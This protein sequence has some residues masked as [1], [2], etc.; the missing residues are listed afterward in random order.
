MHCKWIQFIYLYDHSGGNT[1]KILARNHQYLGVNEAIKAYEARKLNDGKL[2]VFWHTQGSGK[3]YSMV[4]LAQKI[5][6]KFAGS[7]TIVVLT[8]R[9]ELNKQISDTFEN[10]G[11]LGKTNVWYSLKSKDKLGKLSQNVS[12]TMIDENRI[13]EAVDCYNMGKDVRLYRQDKL[14]MK[15]KNY[16]FDLYKTAFRTMWSKRFVI[17]IP[18][19]ITE[20]LVK[21]VMYVFVCAYSIAGVFGVGSIIK[22]V[23]FIKALIDCIT[24]G[25]SVFGDIKYNTPFVR[26]YLTYFD[27]PKKCIRDRLR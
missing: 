24:N 7:P 25:F 1:V 9:D 20:M 16:A 8:N 21:A 5:R 17:G 19:T 26:D 27:I 11:L 6:R 14:I 13:D 3:S 15:I 2:G 23:G 22:Y 10:C 4:F 18:L 12:Q